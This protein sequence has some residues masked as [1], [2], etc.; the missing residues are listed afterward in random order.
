MI[1]VPTTEAQ[2]RL[3]DR[4]M[5]IARTRGAYGCAFPMPDTS[6]PLPAQGTMLRDILFACTATNEEYEQVLAAIRADMVA[7][8]ERVRTSKP[9]KRPIITDIDVTVL[10]LNI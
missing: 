2:Q 7:W 4:A 9:S 8:K 1:E 5:M 3:W 10:D 6:F